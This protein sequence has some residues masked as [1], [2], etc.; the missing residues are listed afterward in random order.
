MMSIRGMPVVRVVAV[1]LSAGLIFAIADALLNANGLAVRLYA[2]YRPIARE[3]VN[4]PLGLAFDLISGLVMAILFVALRPSLSGK[5][6]MRGIQFGLI[7]WFFRVAMQSAS[8]VVMFPIS[9]GAVAYGLSSGLAEMLLLG[10]FYGALLK[11]QEEVAL[12]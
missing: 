4:A 10:I 12:F 7:A 11:P 8:Q 9:A 6:L 1:G 3:S 2:L 5:S